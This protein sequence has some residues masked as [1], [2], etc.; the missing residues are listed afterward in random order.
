MSAQDNLPGEDYASR[1]GRTLAGAEYREDDGAW[2]L[3]NRQLVQ[4]DDECL[5]YEYPDMNRPTEVRDAYFHWRKHGYLAGC[6]HA[7]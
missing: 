5:A 4:C 7:R 3:K 1:N 2:Y 6:S